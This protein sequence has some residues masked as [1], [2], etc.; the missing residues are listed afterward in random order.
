MTTKRGKFCNHFE[1]FF[2]FQR[3][4]HFILMLLRLGLLRDLPIS[5]VQNVIAVARRSSKK[6][7]IN[8]NENAQCG[9]ENEVFK[10]EDPAKKQKQFNKALDPAQQKE[11]GALPPETSQVTTTVEFAAASAVAA[12]AASAASAAAF[13]APAPEVV[14]DAP[15]AGLFSP[16]LSFP[17]RRLRPR[18]AP[19]VLS[20]TCSQVA[21]EAEAEA[22]AEGQAGVAAC[23]VMEDRAEAEADESAA[24]PVTVTQEPVTVMEVNAPSPAT[25]SA[26]AAVEAVEAQH[27]MQ[28]QMQ[29]CTYSTELPVVPPMRCGAYCFPSANFSSS[30]SS[31]FFSSSIDP[32]PV[33]FPAPVTATAT[34]T[35]TL[36]SQGGGGDR[37]R[38]LRGLQ[39]G[40]GQQREGTVQLDSSSAALVALSSLPRAVWSMRLPT[41]QEVLLGLHRQQFQLQYQQQQQQQQ[42][43][44]GKRCEHGCVDDKDDDVVK[45]GGGPAAAVAA[46]AGGERS[47]SGSSHPHPH[48]NTNPL[49]PHNTPRSS[50]NS[51]NSN[52][53][54]QTADPKWAP[55]QSPFMFQHFRQQE[56][57]ES[58]RVDPSYLSCTRCLTERQRASLVNIVVRLCWF[59]LIFRFFLFCFVLFCLLLLQFGSIKL[60]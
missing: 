18:L 53:S 51:N 14:V 22:E 56:S 6:R 29:R 52:N 34:A 7:S 15:R 28:M 9:K 60:Y 37:E 4:F 32:L 30:S 45:G 19:A 11:S 5:E 47:L 36:A 13:A 35:V 58:Y 39:Q 24:V 40:Q 12:T 27:Q 20:P 23:D 21:A 49:H 43:Q 26:S 16:K 44:R 48:P 1:F 2:N 8:R 42:Q 50:H 55:Q 46:A 3:Q 57:R 10:D 17:A 31:S 54:S 38:P 25:A 41:D 59:V 33:P